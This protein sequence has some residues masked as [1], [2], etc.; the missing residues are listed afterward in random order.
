MSPP[1][2]SARPLHALGRF[3]LPLA[4]AIAAFLLLAAL[5]PGPGVSSEEADTLVAAGAGP[6]PSADARPVLPIPALLSRLG[7]GTADQLGLSRHHLAGHRIAS[8]AAGGVLAGLVA[9]LAQG[10]AGTAAG[11]LAPAL[12]LSAPRLLLPLLQAGPRALG[13]CGF[14]AALLAFR[15]ACVGRR[16][17]GRFSGAIGSGLLFGL[18]LSVQLEALALLAA[19]AAHALL[20]P[21]LRLFRPSPAAGDAA[22][23]SPRPRS[24]ATGVL[25]MAL[26]GPVVAVA[27]WPWIWP[28]PLRRVTAALASVPADAPLVHLAR[29]LGPGRPAWGEPAALTALALP[30]TLVL[31]FAA[32]L[33]HTL[34]RLWRALRGGP[35]LS[36]ELL[37]LLAALAPL[38]AAQVGFSARG[39]GVGPWLAAFPLLAVLGARAILSAALAAWPA[40]A[41]A[42][43]LL[44]SAAALAPGIAASVRAFPELGASW[45][46]LAGGTPGAATLGLPRHDG[47]A[48]AALLQQLSAHAR[49]GARVLWIGV[50]PAALAVYARDGRLRPDLAVAASPQEADLAVVALTGGPR[51]GE[52]RAWAALHTSTPAAAAFLDEVPLAWIYVRPGSWR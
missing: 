1:A 18:A 47:E 28:D 33:L 34:T 8:A 10:L 21:L 50:P 3:L 26:L 37:L 25:A 38:A 16:I 29:L 12:L 27:L 22:A 52:Y 15:R 4:W 43:A 40:R 44:L 51:A 41:G 46:E 2:R 45:G 35:G 13:A 20:C 23:P 5:A 49:P 48:G 36:D 6:A 9:L 17:L 32:G 42:L 24:S 30:A 31:A 19:A 7:A 11:L 14:L 39:P